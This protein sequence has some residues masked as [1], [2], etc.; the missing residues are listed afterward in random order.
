MKKV[1]IGLIPA[2][3]ITAVWGTMLYGYNSI[4]NYNITRLEWMENHIDKFDPPATP[5]EKELLYIELFK[6]RQ[7]KNTLTI[8]IYSDLKSL[9]KN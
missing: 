4:C 9:Y 3:F 6:Q 8:I 1:I 2:G 7:Y 5:D